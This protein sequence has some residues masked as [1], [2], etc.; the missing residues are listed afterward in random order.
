MTTT[1][2]RPYLRVVEPPKAQGERGVCGP[3]SVRRLERMPEFQA[4]ARR[5]R[6]EA[7]LDETRRAGAGQYREAGG[8]RPYASGIWWV[9]G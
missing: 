3:D 9:L 7:I 8:L 1:I 6:S 5:V 4:G 2:D